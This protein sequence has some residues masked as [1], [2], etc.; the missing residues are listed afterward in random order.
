MP[1]MLRLRTVRGV[2]V[3]IGRQVALLLVA[4]TCSLTFVV[5]LTQTVRFLDLIIN[6]GL[7][8][9][10]ALYLLSLLLP[11]LLI[12]LLPAALFIAAVFV[13]WRLGTDS[14]L[15]V[16]RGAGMS[17]WQIARP[18]LALALVVAA[19]GYWITLSLA[20]AANQS[21]A[22]LTAEV[23]N[24]FSQVMLQEGV[25]IDVMPGLTVYTRERTAKGALAGV[26]VYDQRNAA[27]PAIYTAA[28]GLVIGSERGPR[29]L[30]EDGTLQQRQTADGPPSIL[31]FERTVVELGELTEA[32]SREPPR[33]EWLTLRQ[34]L[35]PAAAGLDPALAPRYRVE[36]HWRL[37]QPL[38]AL[39]YTAIGLAALLTG[40]VGRRAQARRCGIAVLLVCA[41]QVAAYTA[42][43]LA[44]RAPDMAP[45]LYA[46]PLVPAAAALVLLRWPALAGFRQLR[47]A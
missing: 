29:I 44:I 32:R 6:R 20:P 27:A 7:P 41:L 45:L 16:L 31:S 23:R 18:A 33:M 42:M 43:G 36:A 3:Y 4:I 11:A 13:Y 40:T 46:V 30:L 35:D 15:V 8:F 25:F 34:L 26:L 19:A 28:R 24:D 47:T 9:G 38:F 14:E 10:T 5:W 17:P 2:T 37:S 1:A 22:S 21:L 39:A 12:I